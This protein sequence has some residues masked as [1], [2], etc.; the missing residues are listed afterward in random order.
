MMKL[1]RLKINNF[2]GLKG[3]NNEI[4]FTD[5]N[6]IFLIG[7]N[8]VGK[9]TYLRA[10]EFFTNSGQ[11]AVVEDFYNHSIEKPIIIEGWFVKEDGDEY[12]D[13]LQG[14]GKEKDPSW[15]N[16]WVGFDGLIKIKKEWKIF[17]SIFEKYTFSPEQ[18]D[19]VL[20]G[21]GGMDTLFTKYAPTPIT[22]NAME[23]QASLEEKVNK[24]IQD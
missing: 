11:K 4:D 14:K 16:K 22:I 3:D 20:N 12:D 7:Q 6:I 15:T 19:W 10:Y 8:N 13:E 18:N 17:N 24:L 1:I 2:R 5:S 21:F 23:D 9:S